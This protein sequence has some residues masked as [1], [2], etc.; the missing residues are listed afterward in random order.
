M[1]AS[2]PCAGHLRAFSGADIDTGGRAALDE[3]LIWLRSSTAD[4]GLLIGTA[5]GLLES[6]AKFVLEELGYQ[7][8]NNMD[9]GQIWHIVRE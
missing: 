5:K 7:T 2:V 6:V 8:T 4:P 1:T 9:F 3:Q